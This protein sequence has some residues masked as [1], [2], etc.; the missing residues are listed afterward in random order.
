MMILQD[1]SEKLVIVSRC[2]HYSQT[3]SSD[4]GGKREGEQNRMLNVSHENDVI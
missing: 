1:L 4:N 3:L 2:L